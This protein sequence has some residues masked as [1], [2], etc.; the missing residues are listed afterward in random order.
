M[1]LASGASSSSTDEDVSITGGSS[2]G[3]SVRDLSLLDQIVRM[4]VKYLLQEKHKTQDWEVVSVLHM[5][6]GFIQAQV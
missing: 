4:T 3:D 6:Q 5:V 2:F 1:S